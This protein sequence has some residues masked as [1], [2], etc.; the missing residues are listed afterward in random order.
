MLFT[1]TPVIRM[2]AEHK[3]VMFATFRKKETQ[4][5]CDNSLLKQQQQQQQQQQQYYSSQY[6][7]D[8]KQ[9]YDSVNEYYSHTD[10]MTESDDTD[11]TE[12]V[13]KGTTDGAVDLRVEIQDSPDQDDRYFSDM[14]NDFSGEYY[15][16]SL[17]TYFANLSIIILFSHLL[18][19]SESSR[20]GHLQL[21]M[22]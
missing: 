9:E 5:K 13:E 16:L 10:Y 19:N 18:L 22:S 6:G 8:Y 3:T 14:N 15:Y 21:Q 17:V 7:S 4:L 2:Q 1:S 12:V 20:G 11:D